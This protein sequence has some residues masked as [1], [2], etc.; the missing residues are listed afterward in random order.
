MCGTRS[1]QA[2]LEESG[3]DADYAPFAGEPPL[4]DSRR[5]RTGA[6]CAQAAANVGRALQ[7]AMRAIETANPDK[8]YGIFGDAQWTNKD[9]LP[10]A[11]LREPD[12]ALLARSTSPLANRARGRAGQRLR[13]PHQEV[14][15]RLRPHG[16]RVLHQPHRRPSDDARCSSRSP[17]SR[18]TTPPAAPAAC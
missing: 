12:R 3:G 2:A 4:P 7:N 6:T 15:R 8:L 18:S 9:R 16:R 17:A 1:T 5:T 14:R 13:V 11:T 10:D